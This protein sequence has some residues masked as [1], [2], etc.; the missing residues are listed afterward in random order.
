MKLK[1][2]VSIDYPAANLFWSVS[3]RKCVYA[4]DIRSGQVLRQ[5]IR[6]QACLLQHLLRLH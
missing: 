6:R 4:L 1:M 5:D 3:V 2:C